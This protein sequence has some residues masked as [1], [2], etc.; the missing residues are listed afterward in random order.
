MDIAGQILL[1]VLGGVGLGLGGLFLGIAG[2]AAGPQLLQAA[3]S[4]NL[5]L[6]AISEQV[7]NLLP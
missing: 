7:M 1:N 2:A 4:G 5:D 6:A 3:T